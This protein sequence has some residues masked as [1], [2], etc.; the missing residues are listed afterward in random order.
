MYQNIPTTNIDIHNKDIVP[1]NTFWVAQVYL[2]FTVELNQF[3]SAL[4][5]NIKQMTMTERRN[6][7]KEMERNER[8]NVLS[9]E[10][11]WANTK[12]IPLNEQSIPQKQWRC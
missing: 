10:C 9:M 7:T 11:N 6:Q 8:K 1:S 5:I 3:S 4:P 12:L 2:W